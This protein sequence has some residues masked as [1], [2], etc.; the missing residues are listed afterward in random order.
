M[1][2]LTLN[3]KPPVCYLRLLG[4]LPEG[5]GAE[6][7]LCGKRCLPESKGFEKRT[8]HAGKFYWAL[9]AV[10]SLDGKIERGMPI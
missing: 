3:P 10:Y 7:G 4:R 8:G 1:A 2:I 5:P 6:R 9:S